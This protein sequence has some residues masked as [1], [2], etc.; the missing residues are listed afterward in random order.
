[1]WSYRCVD[2]TERGLMHIIEG[3]FLVAHAEEFATVAWFFPMCCRQGQGALPSQI[4]IGPGRLLGSCPQREAKNQEKRQSPRQ[5]VAPGIC[6]A[7]TSMSA[8]ILAPM[9]LAQRG[10][11]TCVGATLARVSQVV[12]TPDR[13]YCGNWSSKARSATLSSCSSVGVDSRRAC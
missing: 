5:P 13:S 2:P 9:G 10:H 1:C 7:R 4:G 11:L 12:N 8:M 3:H 6:H